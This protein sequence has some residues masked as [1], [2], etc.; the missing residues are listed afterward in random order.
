MRPAPS[1]R[2]ATGGLRRRSVLAFCILRSR[3]DSAHPSPCARPPA[4]LLPS[5][6]QAPPRAHARRAL[7]LGAADD[8]C[9]R[10]AVRRLVSIPNASS[11][12]PL[13][14]LHPQCLLSIPTHRAHAPP[15]ETTARK[16]ASGAAPSDRRLP[17]HHALVSTTWLKQHTPW[18]KHAPRHRPIATAVPPPSGRQDTHGTPP[19]SAHARAA[20]ARPRDVAR[21]GL[22]PLPGVLRPRRRAAP[23]QEFWDRAVAH[24]RARHRVARRGPPATP[25]AGAERPA[26]RLRAVVSRPPSCRQPPTAICDPT[27]AARHAR[28]FRRAPL[29]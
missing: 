14:R 13:P 28:R 20:C 19:R 15:L 22:P 16:A 5:H 8:G 12:S 2:D 6:P 11:P 26:Q 25:R 9:R 3:P 7:A 4:A 21:E 17:K 27:L 24:A 1:T 18:G 29:S 23:R 10:R